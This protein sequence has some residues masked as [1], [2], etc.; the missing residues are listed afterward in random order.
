MTYWQVQACMPDGGMLM[1]GVRA[2]DREAA[3]L[4]ALQ[5]IKDV[6]V[7]VDLTITEIPPPENREHVLEPT[8]IIG[9]L[10]G[11]MYEDDPLPEDR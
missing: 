3:T 4:Q 2:E 6:L 9:P 10:H 5:A 1:L 8:R 7:P 11:R